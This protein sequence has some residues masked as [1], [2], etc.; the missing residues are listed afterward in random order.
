E[1]A[2]A[3]EYAGVDQLVL[4]RSPI[5]PPAL[6]DEPCVGELGLRILVEELHVRVCRCRIEIKV[7]FLHVLAVVALA[8]RDAEEPLL[9]NGVTA[10]PKRQSEAESAVVVRDSCEAV[11]PPS[12]RPRAGVVM[13]EVVPRR[14]VR[15][16]ILPHSSPLPLCQI[17]SPPS[18]V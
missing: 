4:G 18:P 6:L 7:V 2:V 3:V 11:F 17:R 16:V 5:P 13:R 12:V 8:L 14:P 1:V 10:V 15:A 9:E